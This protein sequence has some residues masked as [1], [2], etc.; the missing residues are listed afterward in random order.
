MCEWACVCGCVRHV[1]VR[2][3]VHNNWYTEIT[4]NRESDRKR[5][6][7]TGAAWEGEHNNRSSMDFF[8]ALKMTL[9][10]RCTLYITVA[11]QRLKAAGIKTRRK[12]D[13][14]FRDRLI[15][16]ASCNRQLYLPTRGHAVSSVSCFRLRR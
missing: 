8:L 7:K 6:H 16:V 14:V 9:I 11:G 1:R 4:T 5:G 2:L 15:K 3:H 13:D 10:E 12:E